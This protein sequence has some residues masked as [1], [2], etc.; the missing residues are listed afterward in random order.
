MTTDLGTPA[1]RSALSSSEEVWAHKA[2]VSKPNGVDEFRAALMKGAKNL[3]RHLRRND[4]RASRQAPA[5]SPILVAP[6]SV[7][8]NQPN[9]EG[10]SVSQQGDSAAGPDRHRQ[11]RVG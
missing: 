2:H 7:A 5:P 3:V 10:I 9:E 11:R 1:F 4:P 6:T 8:S